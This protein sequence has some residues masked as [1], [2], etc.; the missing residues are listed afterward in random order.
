MLKVASAS[1]FPVSLPGSA[2]TEDF[3]KQDTK[4]LLDILLESDDL[5]EQADIIHYFYITKYVIYSSWDISQR[6]IV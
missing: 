3:S 2:S 4:S 1:H 5:A 6:C